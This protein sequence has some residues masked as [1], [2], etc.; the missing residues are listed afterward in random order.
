MSDFK[1]VSKNAKV[2]ACYGLETFHITKEEIDALLS[3]K[4]LYSTVNCGEY[5]I[6]IEAE[7]EEQNMVELVIKIPEK[8]YNA[9]T[10]TEFDANLVVDKMRKS[11][12]SGTPLPKGHGRII[13]EPTE[14][15][16]AK[17]IGG[18]NDFAECIRE[19]VKA[20]FDNAQTIIDKESE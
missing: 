11:I 7:S 13:S 20:V 14:E 9:L 8:T 5:A 6:T 15:D 1:I 19:A 12:V 17:T 10:H 18:Q 2:D 4:K 3:G 16:I